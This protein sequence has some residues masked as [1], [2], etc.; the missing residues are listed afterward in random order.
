MGVGKYIKHKIELRQSVENIGVETFG[1]VSTIESREILK[2]NKKG[3]RR[4][5]PLPLRMP[6]QSML[7][8]NSEL[9]KLSTLTTR[10]I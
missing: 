4:R 6:P 2:L 1:C 3:Q 8:M 9:M 5:K 10:G 7:Q